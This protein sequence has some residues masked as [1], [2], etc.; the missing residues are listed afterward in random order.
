MK[1]A[2]LLFTACAMA[3]AVLS[4]CGAAET[5]ASPAPTVSAA[6]APTP[7]PTPQARPFE[8][9]ETEDG[10]Y[11]SSFADLTFT[12]PEG[13]SFATEAELESVMGAGS[14]VM[15]G[16]DLT[17]QQ[18]YALSS[19]VYDTMAYAAGGRPNI[20][21]MF[22]NM[23]RYLGGTAMSEDA[24]LE[25]VGNG[26]TSVE[27]M[28]YELL[29]VGSEMLGA[30]DYRVLTAYEHTMDI[31]QKYYVRRVEDYMLC[32]CLTGDLSETGLELSACFG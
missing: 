17:A 22:E 11:V 24:Y 21:V 7:T 29:G 19:T 6:P 23:T 13:W 16:D 27:N 1:R 14:E 5:Q 28:D 30:Y 4:G 15:F 31:Q 3:L 20:I 10:Q 9:G 12:L 32:I 25:S 2:I 26:L 18:E 8:P